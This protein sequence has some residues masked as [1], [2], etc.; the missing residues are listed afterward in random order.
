MW[1]WWPPVWLFSGSQTTRPRSCTS[2]TCT[3]SPWV[4][5]KQTVSG[6]IQCFGSGSAGIRIMG[7]LIRICMDRGESK[8]LMRIRNTGY[9][10]IPVWET[11]IQNV[12]LF[13]CSSWISAFFTSWIQILISPCGFGSRKPFI[14][15]GSASKK[16]PWIRNRME[17]CGSGSRSYKIL[18]FK[19]KKILQHN[20]I[21]ISK[22]NLGGTDWVD[23]LILVVSCRWK[24]DRWPMNTCKYS[25]LALLYET[26]LNVKSTGNYI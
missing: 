24:T 1:F 9:E 26:K 23:K 8:L 25:L 11:F 20:Q 16:V 12:F 10:Y 7:T 13:F 4:S 18:K 3:T 22:L 21:F 5:K 19:N 2:S 6:H 14:M 15:H 17:R